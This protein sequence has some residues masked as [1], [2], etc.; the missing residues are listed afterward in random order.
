MAVVFIAFRKQKVKT[1][2]S[3]GLL[4]CTDFA[5][6]Q[7]GMIDLVLPKRTKQC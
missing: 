1:H 5:Q 2:L 4:H 3:T 7:T 6:H